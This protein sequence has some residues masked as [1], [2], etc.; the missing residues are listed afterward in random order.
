MHF[1]RIC[2][3][4]LGLGDDDGNRNRG[5]NGGYGCSD[6]TLTQFPGQCR[7][8]AEETRDRPDWGYR[9]RVVRK[10]PRR[11]RSTVTGKTREVV[12]PT[13]KGHG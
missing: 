1:I 10:S 11:L 12:F 13:S 3:G 8:S 5:K 7:D 9:G 4:L 2:A 6:S